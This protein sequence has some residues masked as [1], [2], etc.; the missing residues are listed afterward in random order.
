M[1][2]LIYLFFA[3]C[4][5]F[6]PHAFADPQKAFDPVL[7]KGKVQTQEQSKKVYLSERKKIHE[8][9]ANAA[10]AAASLSRRP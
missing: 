5:L 6:Q 1:S 7:S 3:S 2:S 9:N 10:K 4:F 8:A